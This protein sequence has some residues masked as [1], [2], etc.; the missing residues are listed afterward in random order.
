MLKASQPGKEASGL[1]AALAALVL[2]SA[3]VRQFISHAACA[4]MA[5]P[6]L[7]LKKQR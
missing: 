3:P 4:K 7:S 2:V 5:V 6:F 1:A